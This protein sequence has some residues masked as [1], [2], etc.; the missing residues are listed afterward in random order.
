MLFLSVP[1]LN[2]CTLQ[3]FLVLLS[4]TAKIKQVKVLQLSEECDEEICIVEFNEV[5]CF[6]RLHPATLVQ[7]NE[8]SCFC[9]LHCVCDKKVA[10]APIFFL[11]FLMFC[12]RK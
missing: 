11:F 4:F 2:T 7:Y 9:S 10:F 1:L 12:L 6:Y 3:Y 5:S 8:V